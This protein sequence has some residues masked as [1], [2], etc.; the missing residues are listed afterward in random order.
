MAGIFNTY[1]PRMSLD[2]GRVVSNL[3]VRAPRGQ[4]TTIHGGAMQT[5]RLCYAHDMREALRETI[6]YSRTPEA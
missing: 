1:G 2:E 4:D 6:A 3:V 5:R